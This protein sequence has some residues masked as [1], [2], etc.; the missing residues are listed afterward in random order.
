MNNEHRHILESQLE[1]MRKLDNGPWRVSYTGFNRCD[2]E[3][4]LKGH[5]ITLG[6]VEQLIES[7]ERFITD[8]S[9]RQ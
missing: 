8:F 7:N 1:Q 9:P 2:T 5:S 3:A 4:A 6:S